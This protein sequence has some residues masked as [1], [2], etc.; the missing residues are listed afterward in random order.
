MEAMVAVLALIGTIRWC[1][2]CSRFSMLSGK[3]G[4]LYRDDEN[5]L[6]IACRNRAFAHGLAQAGE[7]QA[8]D[9]CWARPPPVTATWTIWP[10][11]KPPRPIPGSRRGRLSTSR[12][13][14]GALPQARQSL[15]P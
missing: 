14:P 6:W 3:A 11:A 9:R 2:A 8:N 15:Q 4:R 1:L 13:V 7:K 12:P 5:L 10:I